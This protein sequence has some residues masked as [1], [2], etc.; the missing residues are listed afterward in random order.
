MELMTPVFSAVASGAFGAVKYLQVRAKN[1][2]KFEPAKFGYSVA[3]GFILGAGYAFLDIPLTDDIIMQMAT[4]A[5]MNAAGQNLL[6]YIFTEIKKMLT[7][8]EETKE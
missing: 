8:A 3:F 6:E 1:G 7:P 2:E 5:G 4:L